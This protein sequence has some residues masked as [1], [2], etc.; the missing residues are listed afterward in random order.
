MCRKQLGKEEIYY[1]YQETFG[2][3]FNSHGITP[4]ILQ[5]ST[6][7]HTYVCTCDIWPTKFTIKS[8]RAIEIVF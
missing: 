3:F 7:I 6:Y 1:Y 4:Y 8:I 5:L 2:N